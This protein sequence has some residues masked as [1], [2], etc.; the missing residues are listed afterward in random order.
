MKYPGAKIVSL[1]PRWV[2][3]AHDI[4]IM[5]YILI[6]FSIFMRGNM[7]I[8]FSIPDFGCAG[9]GAR[10]SREGPQR[11]DWGRHQGAAGVHAEAKGLLWQDAGCEK[12]HVSSNGE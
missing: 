6:L 9:C 7:W 11:E 12:S 8:F 2:T 1:Y 5:Y 3:Y 4:S 10:M